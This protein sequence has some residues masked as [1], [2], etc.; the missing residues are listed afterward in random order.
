MH[1]GCITVRNRQTTCC[2]LSNH[3]YVGP[4]LQFPCLF[5]SKCCCSPRLSSAVIAQEAP[6]KICIPGGKMAWRAYISFHFENKWPL[7][8]FSIH[9]ASC[10]R[11]MLPEMPECRGVY[12]TISF[13][14][15]VTCHRPLQIV[16]NVTNV[17]CHIALVQKHGQVP[18][19]NMAIKGPLWHWV[20]SG[21]TL[22]PSFWKVSKTKIS[23]KV[24]HVTPSSK[25]NEMVQ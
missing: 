4:S 5:P 12:C 7:L 25:L 16:R 17:L 18:M 19:L 13:N 21:M 20:G 22:S 6:L 1:L 14:L 10:L 23:Y 2:K 24:S 9:M 8:Y 11:S 15:D 3:I